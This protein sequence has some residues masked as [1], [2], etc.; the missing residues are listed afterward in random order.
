MDSTFALSKYTA[1]SSVRTSIPQIQ[2]AVRPKICQRNRIEFSLSVTYLSA[3][4]SPVKISQTKIR[5]VP[6]L[7]LTSTENRCPPSSDKVPAP[8]W[9]FPEIIPQDPFPLSL[10]KHSRLFSCTV[11]LERPEIH[12]GWRASPRSKSPF[13]NCSLLWRLVSVTRSVA[14]I[15]PRSG[16]AKRSYCLKCGLA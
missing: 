5:A 10:Q 6:S 11:Q 15:G 12:S 8:Q 7:T 2:I 3:K 14:W 16:V 4:I 13:W 9:L 1:P